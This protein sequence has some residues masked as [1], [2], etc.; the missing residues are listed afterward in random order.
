M[1]YVDQQ[2]FIRRISV[3]SAAFPSCL[4]FG[5]CATLIVLDDQ[6]FES[7]SKKKNIE[8]D[9]ES[10][11]IDIVYIIHINLA[12]QYGIRTAYC[13]VSLV[14]P[15]NMFP[16]RCHNVNIRIQPVEHELVQQ[17]IAVP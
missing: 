8:I 1:N 6:A 11:A 16:C 12:Y 4:V 2:S 15:S 3:S 13:R 5:H 10:Y 14:C 17:P 9:K 7:N